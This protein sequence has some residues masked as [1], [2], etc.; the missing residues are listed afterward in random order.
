M[1]EAKENSIYDPQQTVAAQVAKSTYDVTIQAVI[2][3]VKTYLPFLRT[4]V[5]SQI[6]DFVITKFMNLLYKEG[7]KNAA[8]LIIDLNVDKQ[9]EEYKQASSDLA[10]AINSGK[11]K[12]EIEAERQKFKDRLR[13]LINMRP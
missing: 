6:V 11:T 10:N 8:L 5:I 3:I 4:P 9:S 2:Q 1:S 13:D 12:D 7:Q